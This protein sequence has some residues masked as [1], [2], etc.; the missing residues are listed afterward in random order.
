MQRSTNVNAECMEEALAAF[1]AW[2][3]PG[4]K[5]ILVLLVDNAGGHTAKR[6]VVPAIVPLHQPPSC[7]PQLQPAERLWRYRFSE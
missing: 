2:A 4:G 5:T 7:T 3:S 1:A 6:L